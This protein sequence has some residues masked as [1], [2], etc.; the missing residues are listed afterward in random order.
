M[1][2]I[3]PTTKCFHFYGFWLATT[4][5]CLCRDHHLLFTAAN[6]HLH[7]VYTFK[8]SDWLI[9]LINLRALIIYFS[10]YFSIYFSVIFQPPIKGLKL[11]N[12]KSCS[13]HYLS[14]LV[15]ASFTKKKHILQLVMI[16]KLHSM[17]FLEELLTKL[18]FLYAPPIYNMYFNGTRLDPSWRH[19]R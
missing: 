6:F 16:I 12:S 7:N 3:S 11:G 17:F 18:I 14:F 13:L 5:L 9:L 8:D 2:A 4:N 1:A 19:T 10:A 15:L